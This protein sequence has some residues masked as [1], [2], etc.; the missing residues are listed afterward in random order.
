MFTMIIKHCYSACTTKSLGENQIYLLYVGLTIDDILGQKLN[1]IQNLLICFY[2]I[3][4]EVKA[5]HS[6]EEIPSYIPFLYR[7]Q[8]S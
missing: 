8:W 6:V 5:T 4:A 1:N 2:H 7:S 3:H